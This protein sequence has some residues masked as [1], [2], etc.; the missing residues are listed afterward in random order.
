M[1]DPTDPNPSKDAANEVSTDRRG[2][3]A[4]IL[5]LG[6][7]GAE[8]IGRRMGRRFGEAF[9]AFHAEQADP[10]PAPPPAKDNVAR[11]QLDL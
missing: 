4:Q 3:F 1:S 6:V 7:D 10:P 9:G 11:D 5:G 8:H 2:F